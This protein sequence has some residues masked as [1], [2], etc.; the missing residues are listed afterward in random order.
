MRYIIVAISILIAVSLGCY[1]W[2]KWDVRSFEDRIV[3]THVL[4]IEESEPIK[5]QFTNL[6]QLVYPIRIKNLINA[7]VIR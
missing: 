5:P 6:T 4:Q 3:G 7:Q 2:Y 1:T